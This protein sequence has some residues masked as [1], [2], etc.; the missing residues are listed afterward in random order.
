MAR[1]G[2]PVDAV[3]EARSALPGEPVGS[4]VPGRGR[5]RDLHERPHGEPIDGTQRAPRREALDDLVELMRPAVQ[6]D[7]GDIAIVE[8]DY[9]SG[10]VDVPAARCVRS[11][12]SFFAVPLAGW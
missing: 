5:C 11:V 4:A 2:R 8:V 9:D 7:G 10:V 3:N 12:P 6:A 1:E